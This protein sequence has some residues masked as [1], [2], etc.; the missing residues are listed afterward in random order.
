M[1]R[2]ELREQRP[3]HN[4]GRTR[5]Q[6]WGCTVLLGEG[7]GKESEARKGKRIVRQRKQLRGSQHS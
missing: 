4:G 1:V 2:S 5:F 6:L 3:K 7:T